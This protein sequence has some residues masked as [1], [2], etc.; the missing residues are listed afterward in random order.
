IALELKPRIVFAQTSLPDADG[1][2][3]FGAH[4]G[5][6]FRPFLEAA[7]DPERLAIAEAN[8]KMPRV[9]GLA[10]HG[11]NRVHVSAIDGWVENE[12]ELTALP[13]A[14]A[15]AEDVAIAGH[16]AERI[17]VGSTLQFG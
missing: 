12:T 11:G 14:E 8:P 5:A 17:E 13:D 1:Y 15:S 7:A 3:N 4:A 16:V 9:A 10:E 2:L 6:T